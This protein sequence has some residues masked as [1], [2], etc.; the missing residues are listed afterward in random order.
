MGKVAAAAFF[1][2]EEKHNE[3]KIS[4]KI[5]KLYVIDFYDYFVSI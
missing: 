1:F 3:N 4:I 5:N 2:A